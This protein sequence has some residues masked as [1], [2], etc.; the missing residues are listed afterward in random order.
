MAE[1][2]PAK[3]AAKP[4]AKKP[5]AAKPE[6]KPAA[7]KPAAAKPAAKPAAKKP[8]A[9]KPAAK[10]AAKKPAAAKQS[11]STGSATLSPE[12]AA[13]HAYVNRESAV[14][15]YKQLPKSVLSTWPAEKKAQYEDLSKKHEASKKIVSQAYLQAMSE[16]TETGK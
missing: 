5:A 11:K 14:G 12:E 4:A 15:M 3:P 16:P 2:K 6:V 13:R 8:A 10:P 1:K 7:K 9:A